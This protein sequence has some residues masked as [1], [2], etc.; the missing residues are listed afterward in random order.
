MLSAANFIKDYKIP[1]IGVNTGRLGFL[2]N[3]AKENILS[4]IPI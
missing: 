2:A 3:V 1:I 4:L